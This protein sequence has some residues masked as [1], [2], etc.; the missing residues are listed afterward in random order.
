MNIYLYYGNWRDGYEVG[1]TV[2]EIQRKESQIVAVVVLS[3]NNRITCFPSL[4]SLATY[5]KIELSPFLIIY[6]SR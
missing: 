1:Y 6:D 2:T 3:P 4:L 5:S